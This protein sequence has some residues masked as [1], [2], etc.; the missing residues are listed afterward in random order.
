MLDAN[1]TISVP[2]STP[3]MA[4]PAKVM[5]AAPGSDKAVTAT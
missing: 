3:K 2:A 5:M 1:D 4:P